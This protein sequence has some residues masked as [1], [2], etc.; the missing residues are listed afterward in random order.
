MQQVSGRGVLYLIACGSAA[1][2]DVVEPGV[3]A[4]QAA[5]WDVCVVTTPNGKHFL[6]MPRLSRLTGHP[7]RSEYKMPDTPD[8]LPPADALL[9]YPATFKTINTWVVGDSST[10]AVGLL[11]EYLGLGAPIVAVPCLG[12]GNGLHK[13]PVFVENLEKLRRWGVRVL[14][15]PESYPPRNAIPAAIVL[16]ALHQLMQEKHQEK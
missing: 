16:E 14:Y 7:I 13:H 11:C 3:R 10:L 9:V 6:N 12:M 8:L 1:A 15:E 2:F 5:G 4:A